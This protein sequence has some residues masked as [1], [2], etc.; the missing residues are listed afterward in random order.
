MMGTTVPHTPGCDEWPLA[1]KY[2]LAAAFITIFLKNRNCPAVPRPQTEYKVVAGESH[3][4]S[5]G[6]P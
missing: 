2:A 6:A 5:S 3:P 1:K 4:G